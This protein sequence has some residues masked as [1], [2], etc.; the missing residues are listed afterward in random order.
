MC[1]FFHSTNHLTN[2]LHSAAFP[3][4]AHASVKAERSGVL[5]GVVTIHLGVVEQSIH[6]LGSAY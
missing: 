1:P 4:A 5:W 6:S 2:A 3:G